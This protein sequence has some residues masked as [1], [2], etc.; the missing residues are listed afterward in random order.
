VTA[1][2]AVLRTNNPDV[3]TYAEAEA[4]LTNTAQDLGEPGFDPVF[5]H[6]LVRVTDL[7]GENDIGVEG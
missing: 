1:A 2:L 5:G 3:Q 4:L 6:G 7:C